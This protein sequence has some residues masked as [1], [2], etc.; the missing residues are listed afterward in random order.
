[1]PTHSISAAELPTAL[2]INAT[3]PDRVWL[4]GDQAVLDRP[5]LAFFCSAKCTGGAILQAY[6]VARALR[7]AGVPVVGG[8]HSPMEKECLDLLLRGTQSV[9][10]C[11]A[12]MRL[13]APWREA[14][15]AGRLLIASPFD[16][17]H[18]RATAALAEQR[19]RFVAS[20]AR[21]I[22]IVHAS[23]G[24][25]L[26]SLALEL[27]SKGRRVFVLTGPADIQLCRQGAI[28]VSIESLV[29]TAIAEFPSDS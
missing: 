17:S 20:L 5:L 7:D 6:D 27:L 3:S 29:A 9:V 22:L 12:R 26:E 25:K 24:G 10:V 8:F 11:P 23:P 13:P 14:I 2:R 15:D 28:A 16:A 4:I 18:R 19:N 21:D 1:M